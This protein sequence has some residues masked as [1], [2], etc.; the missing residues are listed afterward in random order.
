M[1]YKIVADSVAHLPTV[2]V[3][4]PWPVTCVRRKKSGVAMSQVEEKFL[5]D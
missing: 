5:T 4:C 2:R 1:V 3:I